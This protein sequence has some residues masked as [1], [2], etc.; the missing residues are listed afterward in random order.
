MNRKRKRFA[1]EYIIDCNGAQAAIRAGY[2]KKTARTQAAQLLANL[3]VKQEIDR[4][5]AK[6]AQEA[7]LSVDTVLKNLRKGIEE[8]WQRQPPDLAAIARFSEL[9][10]K[11]LAMFTDKHITNTERVRELTEAE[12]EEARRLAAIRLQQPA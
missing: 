9:Q 12:H 1:Q 7:S 5:M 2:S 11:Y 6:K 10:G 8:A 3:S 4:L